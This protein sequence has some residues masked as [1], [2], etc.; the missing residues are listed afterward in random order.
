VARLDTHVALW[1]ATGATD[2]LSD[3]VKRT[4]EDE[5]LTISPLVELELTYLYEIGRLTAEGPEIVEQLQR[6]IGLKISPITLTDAVA[7][8][9]SLSWTRDPFDRLIVAD[10]L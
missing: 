6:E 8:A 2:L 7:A 5:D 9:H 10:A 4:I 1:L 3:T